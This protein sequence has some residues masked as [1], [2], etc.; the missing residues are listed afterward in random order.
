MQINLTEPSGSVESTIMQK[1]NILSPV[2]DAIKDLQAGRMVIVVDDEH[3]ENEGDLICAAQFTTPDAINFMAT[4]ARGLLCL[5][6]ETSRLEE[7]NILPMVHENSDPH[8]T[9][10]SVSVDA[11]PNFGVSTGISA[12]DR[13]RTVQ[14][15][16][17]PHT[18]P[19]DLRRPGHVFPLRTRQGGVLVRAGHTEASVDLM[20]AAGL[21]PAAVIC[22][23]QNSD[24]SMARLPDLVKYAGI[25][26]LKV[27]SIADLI[28]FRLRTERLVKREAITELPTEF[29]M[30]KAYAY[31]NIVDDSE[32]VA[33]VRG[34]PEKFSSSEL[35][36]RVHSECLTGDALGSLRC[37][38]RSQLHAALKMLNFEGSGVLL[39]LRQEGRGIGLINK[40][41]AYSL[42]DTGLDT[43]EANEKL[44]FKPDLRNYGIGAQILKDLGISRIKIITNN[45]R[46]ISELKGFG[47]DVVDRIPLNSEVNSHN[48]I[49]LSAK[50]D[51][52]D[53]LLPSR[54]LEEISSISMY[55]A[56]VA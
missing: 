48:Y 16:I 15:C 41:K 3:R 23:I 46:K 51:K 17:N 6:M 28:D 45:P 19:A 18:R 50:V 22:E 27:V 9:A 26:N 36:V 1:S 31:R 47:L 8:K 52:L 42:Q 5:S 4:H 12:A 32:H 13:S 34:D 33:L 49:Y 11:S 24:G 54:S 53:H 14:A 55:D 38:C 43:V 7:L 35:L 20:K 40:L 25:H 29:G 44:G 56:D 10:F 39:Y 2:T 30:F 37:D 21:Y